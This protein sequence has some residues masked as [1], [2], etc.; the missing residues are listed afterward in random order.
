MSVRHGSRLQRGASGAARESARERRTD[1]FFAGRPA[2]RCGS[3]P[4]PRW[5]S[6]PDPEQVPSKITRSK[7]RL[8]ID[9]S[10]TT[11]SSGQW[12]AS[13]YTIYC[14]NPSSFQQQPPL[15]VVLFMAMALPRPPLTLPSLECARAWC[16]DTMHEKMSPIPSPCLAL[17]S[18]KWARCL[19]ARASTSSA[20]TARV[21]DPLWTRSSFVPTTV[22]AA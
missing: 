5:G 1:F 12:P 14:P 2:P 8:H 18:N 21:A 11:R 20:R 7:S 19:A 16:C 15:W 13:R 17:V 3:A 22:H 4:K 6:G 9:C 10:P